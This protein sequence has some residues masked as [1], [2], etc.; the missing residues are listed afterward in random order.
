VSQTHPSIP[1]CRL[2]LASIED[3]FE[4]W[5]DVAHVIKG[6]QM[7]YMRK[8][9]LVSLPPSPAA[10]PPPSDSDPQRAYTLV[11]RSC[12][13][14][15]AVLG[16]NEPDSLPRT[17]ERNELFDILTAAPVEK[18]KFAQLQAIKQARSRA[19]TLAAENDL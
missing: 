19:N 10:A 2:T 9:F 18:P 11:C 3:P 5:Y 16:N 8:E 12:L 17:V 14:D 15:P 1:S 7:S 4:S 13:T 6:T